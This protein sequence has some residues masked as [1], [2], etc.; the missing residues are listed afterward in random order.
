MP[1][2]RKTETEKCV[3]QV[4]KRIT[5]T[6]KTTGHTPGAMRA[7]KRLTVNQAATYGEMAKIIDEETHAGELL[8]AL[9]DLFEHCAMVH[10]YWGDG[11]NAK[12]AAAAIKAGEAAIASATKE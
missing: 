5:M 4:T 1:T 10:K 8:T 2:T 6:T 12:E 9:K 7:V 3:E 11:S